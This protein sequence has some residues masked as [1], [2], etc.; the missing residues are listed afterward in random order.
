MID[1]DAIRKQAAKARW[2]AA[3]EEGAAV[4]SLITLDSACSIL[5]RL[6]GDES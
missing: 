2:R 4:R 3:E 5:P 1:F 6:L